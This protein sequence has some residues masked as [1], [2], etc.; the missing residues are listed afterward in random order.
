ML[1]QGKEY[2]SVWR[3]KDV[4]YFVDQT[5]LPFEF[6]IFKSSS[7]KETI[8]AIK[9]MIVRGAPAIG[10]AGA[11]AYVQAAYEY[12]LEADKLNLAA[13]EIKSARPTAVDLM[14]MLERMK[15]IDQELDILKKQSEKI[16]NEIIEACRKVS[17]NGSNL[18]KMNDVILTHCHTGAVAAV[19]YGTALGA[20]KEAYKQNKN[21][22]VYVDESRPRM[23]GRLTSWELLEEGV[24][25]KVIVDGAAGSLMK[26]GKINMVIVGA[27]RICKNGDFANKI[28]TYQL[29]VLAKENK[30]PF[31]VAAPLTTFDFDIKSGTDITIE[32]RDEN[33][34]L[35]VQGQRVY[36]EGSHAFNPAFDV[37]SYTYVSGYITESGVFKD[38]NELKTKLKK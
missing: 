21:I 5:K 14:N 7:Y 38:I 24:P 31:Y 9:K 6:S 19:D 30:I 4:V 29:A 27:D 32:E 12:K 3:E 17:E 1:I 10:V 28:G 8:E 34:V 20:I 18:I 36:P 13:A 26:S 15:S 22:F 2:R 35:Y 16:A 33:E 23:Q 37:T 25:H 11:Y